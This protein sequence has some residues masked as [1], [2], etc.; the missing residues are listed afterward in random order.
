MYRKDVNAHSPLRILEKSIHGGLGKG[1]LGVVMARAGVGKT[2]CL[3][4]IALDDLMRE[5][6]VLHV[7]LEQTIDHVQSWYDAL[8]D[9]LAARTDLE[10]VEGVRAM[11][12]KN[13]VITAFADRDLWPERLEKTAAMFREHLDFKPAA[14]LVDGYSWQKHS[15]AENGAMIGALKSYA[16]LHDAELWMSAQT[17]R[18]TTGEH[19]TEIPAPCKEYESLIDVVLY[20]EPHGKEIGV[21]LLK[22]HDGSSGPETHLHLHPDALRLVS[23]EESLAAIPILP[24]SV[25][26]LLSGG[27]NGAEEQFGECA[28]KWGLTELNFSYAGREAA[29]SRGIVQ[30][31]DDELEQGDVSQV[32]LQAHMHREYPDT[33]S[34]QKLLKTIWHQVNTAGEVFAVGE[35][36]PDKTMRG[37]TGWAVELARHQHKSVFVFDQEQNTWFTWSD[38]D[39]DKIDAPNISSRR[40]TG[41]GTRNLNDNGR[42]AIGDLFE[43]SFGDAEL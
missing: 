19:P 33:E 11:I 31:T 18:G 42:K 39:W 7:A 6:A 41:T 9:D 12:T 17:H 3:V 37:G 25:F 34:F 22:D 32:Y 43:R 14:I 8:F 4:Q 38:N 5:K 36:L 35:L 13:R 16:K 27:A 28:E 24:S 15:V 10:D 21:R 26:T 2:A 23:S 30:L 29:R 20:L 1:N 40:F